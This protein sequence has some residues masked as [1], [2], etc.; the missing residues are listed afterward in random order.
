MVK[1]TAVNGIEMEWEDHGR[2]GRALVLVH[3]FTGARR[4]FA[5]RVPALAALGRT[6]L[7]DLRGHGGSTN[8]GDAAGYTLDRLADDLVAFLDAEGLAGCDLLGHSLG[9][10]VVLR[11]ALA[12]PDRIGSLILVN[13]AARAPALKAETLAL[14]RRVVESAG[15]EALLALLRGRGPDADRTPADRR[16]EAA[17]G[18]GYWTEWR[19]PNYRAMDPVAFAALGEALFAQAPLAE[20]LGEIRAPALVMVGAEDLA[21]LAAAD[22][23]AAGIPGARRVTIAGAGHQPQ[24]ETPEAWLEAIRAHLAQVRDSSGVAAR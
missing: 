4:D 1:R 6:V 10:M 23:L 13:T 24:L 14:A 8:T 15:L 5:P 12:A 19:G 11:A 21:F 20:R 9:G 2:G 7:P 22:E 3:G 16:L 17:W 18:E